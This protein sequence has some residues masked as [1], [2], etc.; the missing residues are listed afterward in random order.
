ML[1]LGMSLLIALAACGNLRAAPPL[2]LG[3]AQT[4]EDIKNLGR[5]GDVPFESYEVLFADGTFAYSVVLRDQ[6]GSVTEQ[7]AE[8]IATALY[9]RVHG[10]PP[11]SDAGGSAGA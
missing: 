5:P 9:K 2:T 3:R 7:E 11:P 6:P 10:A 8:K 4:A 1:L